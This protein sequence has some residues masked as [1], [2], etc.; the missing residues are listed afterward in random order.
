[1]LMKGLLDLK[2]EDFFQT[3]TSTTTR[4]HCMKVAKLRAVT[5]V[6]RNQWNI[7]SVN[8]WNSLPNHVVLARSINE[9][10]NLLDDFWADH[11]YD[12]V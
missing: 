11:V 6:R 8:D 5:R 10:K 2:R 4:G 3:P 7:R 1:M 12:L 9:F